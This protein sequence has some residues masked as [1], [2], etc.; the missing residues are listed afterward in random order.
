MKSLRLNRKGQFSI[1][2]ALFAAAI[3]ISSVMVTYSTIRYNTSV[4]Q[5]QIMNAV[6]ETNLALK[7]VLGFTVGYYGSVMQ[8]T[9]NSSYAYTESE[10]YLNSGLNNIVDI[11]PQWGTSFSVET[12][13]LGTCWFTN[14]SWSQGNLNVTYNLPGLGIYGIAYSISSELSVQVL[15]S[16]SQEQVSLTVTQ[17]CNQP[18]VSLGRSNFKFY[19]YEDSNLTWGMVYPS[20]DPV[21]SS[22]GTY[23]LDIP[24]GI[25]PQSFIIQVQD[26]RGIMVSA[27]SFSHY[28]GTLTFNST[29]VTGGNYVNQTNTQ[30]DGLPDKGTHSNFAAQ[31]QAPNGVYDTLTETNVGTQTQ[32]YFPDSYNAQAGTSLLS[33]TLASLNRDDY[34][35]MTFQSYASAYSGSQYV[36]TT[37]DYSNGASTNGGSSL[38]WTHTTGTGNDRILLV[39]IDTFSYSGAPATVSSV[40]YGSTPVTLS[41]TAQYSSNPQVRSYIYYLTNP[42]SGTYTITVSFS[43]ST[44][45]SAGSSTYYNVDQTSPINN[46]NSA[47]G[48]GSSQSVS[49][50]TSGA[51][52]KTLYADVGA[53]ISSSYTISDSGGQNNRWSNTGSYK[54]GSTNYYFAGRGSDKSSSSSPIS[55]S[56]TTTHSVNWAA[57][58]VLLQPSKLPT[59]ETCQIVFSGSSN[60]L[61]WDRLNWAIDALSSISTNVQMQLYNYNSGQYPSSGDGYLAGT[62][63]TSNSTAVQTITANPTNFRDSLGRWQIC[64]TATASVSTPFTVSV[65]LTRFTS[66]CTI[67]GANFEE[68]WINLNTTALLHPALCIDA[69]NVGSANL[70][71]SVWYGNAWQPLSSGLVS[72]WNNMSINSF[73]PSGSINFTIR[74]SAPNGYIRNSWQVAAALIR[75][76]SNLDLFNSLSNPSATVAV[77]LLQNGTMIWLGQ[78]LQVT[79]QTVP[80]PPVPVK[81]LH[82]NETVG[83]VNQQVPFQIEDWASSYTVPLGLTDNATVFGNRQMVVFLVNTHVS[84]FTLW[85]NGSSQAVQ[86]PLAFRNTQFHDTSGTLNNGQLSVSVSGDSLFTVTSTVVGKS[87]SS[88]ANFM[89]INTNASTYGAGSAFVIVNGV[90]RDI[91]QQEAEWINGV[92]A[93]ILPNG[94]VLPPTC[95]T[96]YANIV[97]TLPADA[98][99]LPSRRASSS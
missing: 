75:P 35:D 92:G 1:I 14:S 54:H 17:D 23:T 13:Q 66:G 53:Q 21:V 41:Y 98:S 74:F 28:T 4:S 12:L 2:A 8:V 16:A 44:A 68:Q 61:S 34:S 18:V 57:V 62:L 79:G 38:Q 99:Y 86:T 15:H 48:S 45:A 87:T 7:Q 25:N 63:T 10:N 81:A 51:Y 90:V 36:T 32:D 84:A 30:I 37:Y 69:G 42:A 85:W 6:D 65:D 31:Q 47:T 94:S 97:L 29:T 46:H 52:A 24:S 73:L 5:P 9:G 71:L 26:Q 56:W 39:S 67:Y 3:L 33:G 96:I 43:S 70:A 78:N 58:A 59:Q 83:G 60:T 89:R 88:L 27:S 11:N 77:E 49:V 76:E 50:T 80:I 72:G 95:R 19:L 40:Q 64:L 22:D 20:D 91:I 82:V 55:L 93:V